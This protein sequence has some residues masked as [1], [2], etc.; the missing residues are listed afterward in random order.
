MEEKALPR[1]ES[2]KWIQRIRQQLREDK[3]SGE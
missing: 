3:M 1:E 2:L